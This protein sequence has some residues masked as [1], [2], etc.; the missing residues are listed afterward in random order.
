[1]ATNNIPPTILNCLALFDITEK[2][3]MPSNV[4]SSGTAAERDDE[5][6]DAEQIS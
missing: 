4:Q 1:M 6:H 5:C 2:R 3:N